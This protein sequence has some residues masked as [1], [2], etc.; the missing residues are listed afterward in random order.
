MTAAGVGGGRMMASGGPASG[1]SARGLRV[2]GARK[3][4]RAR[5]WLFVSPWVIGFLGLTIGPLLFSLFMS[6]AAWDI[7][8]PPEGVGV[9]NYVELFTKD[10]IFLRAMGTTVSYAVWSVLLGIL[11]SVIVA[12]FLDKPIRGRSAFRILVFLPS[13]I[14]LVAAAQLFKRVLSPGGLLNQVLGLAGIEGPAWLLDSRSVLWAFIIMSLW[15]VGGSTILVLAGI[16]GIPRT[17]VE[18]A[19]IDG[20]SG[21]S[22]FRHVT[23]PLL[24]PV[25]FYNVVMGLIG[26][27][28][29][30]GQVYIMTGG[31]PD[32][33]SMMI[34]PHLYNN[35]F[36]DYQM[37]Y[38]SAMAWVLFAVIM[39]LSVLVFRSSSLWVFYESE[40]RKT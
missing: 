39:C 3:G 40:V 9:R 37:G 34:V 15:N 23:L 6:F 19:I 36:R 30:F 1:S 7:F 28:Q 32:N 11:A 12:Y 18:S 13:V 2:H 31:G 20:A 26:G 4:D 22:V 38:A 10:P 5:F 17:L 25:I 14:P 35:A 27:L 21:P 29:T 8:A 33:A 24:S 16:Q